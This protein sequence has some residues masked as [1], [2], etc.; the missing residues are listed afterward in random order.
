ML[1]LLRFGLWLA[2]LPGQATALNI[3]R[4]VAAVL[5]RLNVD[6]VGIA[7]INI[8]SCLPQLSESERESLCRERLT[9]MVLLFFEF[10]QLAHWSEH[11]LLD[12]IH[13]MQG[14]ALLDEAYASGR[15]VVLLVPHLGNWE[16]FCAFLG[17][18]YNFAALYAPPKLASLESLM[19][20]A[21][22]RFRGEL[23]PIDTGGMRSLLRVLKQGKL[24]AILP[25]Q[26][27]ERSA[28]VYADFFGQP[29]LTMTLI[30]RLLNKNDP[31]VLMGT[32][33]R[34]MQASGF[35]YK[36]CVERLVD[37]IEGADAQTCCA[38]MNKSIERAVLRAPDQYQWEYKRFKRP[39][40]K[41]V[42]DR[43]RRQ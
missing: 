15:G 11:K 3:S 9:Q 38:V 31:V 29:A 43:Y 12:Q 17:A 13:D 28:G 23:F 22:Q 8:A 34:V 35:G 36:V 37:D 21:R 39:P 42:G 18:H 40:V 24:V 4:W 7:R 19:L 16:L 41:G 5:Y 30:H 6:V 1:G 25:D 20:N 14:K 10:A 32:V 27:P 33:E 26:V 2:R